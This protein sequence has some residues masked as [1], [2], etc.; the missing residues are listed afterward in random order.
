MRRIASCGRVEI[1]P[2]DVD[3]GGEIRCYEMFYD[4]GTPAITAN[5]CVG[6]EAS[7]SLTF[8][9]DCCAKRPADGL[10]SCGVG[11]IPKVDTLGL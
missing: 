3:R 11:A 2:E 1:L 10:Q 5:T 7:Q 4:P 6:I 8:G 9:P